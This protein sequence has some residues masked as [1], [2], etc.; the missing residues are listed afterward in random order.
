MTT[1]ILETV[2]LLVTTVGA[3]FAFLHLHRTSRQ[4][5]SAPIPAECAPLVRDR[6]LLMITMG[7]MA[8][9]FVI[10]YIGLILL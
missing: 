1:W 4:M 5:G 3:L 10:Q 7:L 9:W 6:R 2:G 8:G